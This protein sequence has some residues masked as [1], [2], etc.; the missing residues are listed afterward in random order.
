MKL[1]DMIKDGDFAKVVNE[2]FLDF[3]VEKGALVFVAGV[4]AVPEDEND[5]YNQR[6]KMLIHRMDG[7]HVMFEKTLIMV[8]PR[9]LKRVGKRK[10]KTLINHLE[11]DVAMYNAKAAE[12]VA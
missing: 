7:D 1:E 3:D 4:K 2:N 5:L 8:D 12:E 9:S 11:K 6:I 10:Q